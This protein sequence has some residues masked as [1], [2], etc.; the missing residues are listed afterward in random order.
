MAWEAPSGGQ[1]VGGPGR[2][3]TNL[4]V[5]ADKVLTQGRGEAS[6]RQDTGTHGAQT[7]HQPER[8]WWRPP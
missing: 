3:E 7:Q 2:H 5:A 1:V 4:Q 8:M 6:E